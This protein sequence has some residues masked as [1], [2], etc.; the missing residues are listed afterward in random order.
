MD[1]FIFFCRM[2]NTLNNI[3]FDKGYNDYQRKIFSKMYKKI[4]NKKRLKNI[5]INLN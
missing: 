2:K 3:K 1:I 5:I 4:M